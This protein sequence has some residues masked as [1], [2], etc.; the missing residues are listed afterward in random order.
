MTLINHPVSDPPRRGVRHLGVLGTAA[1]VAV[2]VG[3]LVGA[4][5]IGIGTI[6]IVLG[7]VAANAVI[8][9]VLALRGP[10]A[11]PLRMTGPASHAVNIVV[12]I[13]MLNVFAVPALLFYGSAML[14]A[15]VR[16]YGACEMFAA[17][18]WLRRRDDQFGCPFFLPFDLLDQHQSGRSGDC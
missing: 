9:G 7:V 11:P 16:G 14:L 10:D 12:P 17:S 13:V 15:A 5:Q 3:F 6:D 2:G 8:I 4:A 18:N 1:R